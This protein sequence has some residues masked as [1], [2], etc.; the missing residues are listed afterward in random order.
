MFAW[1]LCSAAEK[2]AVQPLGLPF[3]SAMAGTDDK[4]AF[5]FK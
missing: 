1:Y 4:I 5:V 2:D 3:L